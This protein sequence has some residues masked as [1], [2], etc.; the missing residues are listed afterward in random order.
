[1]P[2]I[3]A[4][5]AT[6]SAKRR[7]GPGGDDSKVSTPAALPIGSAGV[8]IGL[9][10]RAFDPFASAIADDVTGVGH[11]GNA[12][13]PGDVEVGGDLAEVAKCNR[14]DD[15]VDQVK[16]RDREDFEP[17]LHSREDDPDNR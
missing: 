9:K 6:N 3:N 16:R 1:M 15:T 17:P 5:S 10:W 11:R 7:L 8:L 14:S 2:I 13:V 4:T 12:V